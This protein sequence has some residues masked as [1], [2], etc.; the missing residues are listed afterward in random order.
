MTLIDTSAWIEFL[1]RTGDR[2]AKARVAAYLELGTAAH[3]GPIAF[4]LLAGARAP[5]LDDLETALDLSV[6]LDFPL[7]CWKR[8][9]AME[10][11][12]RSRGV[13]V[14]RDDIFVAAAALHGDVPLYSCDPHFELMRDRGGL[15]LRL[16]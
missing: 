15:A 14:P 16:A 6:L 12:L 4:E 3:C 7:A 8:A 2:D 9:A 11:E 13:T 5:E 1:R 10:R